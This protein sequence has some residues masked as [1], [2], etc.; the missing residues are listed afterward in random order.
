[1]DKYWD[2]IDECTGCGRPWH[3]NK[4]NDGYPT[5]LFTSSRG[6]VE[7]FCPPCRE[8]DALV[9]EISEGV[10]KFITI[11]KNNNKKAQEIFGDEIEELKE[12]FGGEKN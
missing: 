4:R 8:K 11:L 2:Y 6:D 9:W 7:A 1:M 10:T 12:L 5:W 3:P